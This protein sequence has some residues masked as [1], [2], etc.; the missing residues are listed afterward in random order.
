MILIHWNLYQCVSVT[1][2]QETMD[3]YFKCQ[4][5]VVCPVQ[6]ITDCVVSAGG[7]ALWLSGS[8][9]FSWWSGRDPPRCPHHLFHTA[10][11]AIVQCP[12][13]EIRSLPEG[14][15]MQEPQPEPQWD[16]WAGTRTWAE[17]L[18]LTVGNK[19]GAEAHE[20]AEFVQ[21]EGSQRRP[22]S[23]CTAMQLQNSQPWP[24]LYPVRR[25]RWGSQPY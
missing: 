19:C 15:F 20:P 8:K 4:S 1:V 2:F 11:A 21:S 23:I 12:H 18:W 17:H 6:Y 9:W 13:A 22:N 10:S 24:Q 16:H 3:S 25:H 7:R 14:H 5:Y